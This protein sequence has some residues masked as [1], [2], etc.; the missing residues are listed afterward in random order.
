M[1]PTQII[2]SLKKIEPSIKSLGT[3]LSEL[4]LTAHVGTINKSSLG[5]LPEELKRI[6]RCIRVIFHENEINNA[7][8]Q[9][10]VLE[11][12]Y[13]LKIKITDA[14]DSD[15]KYIQAVEHWMELSY[16]YLEFLSDI[17]P[18]TYSINLITSEE[19]DLISKK[20]AISNDK[21][22]DKKI[23]LLHKLRTL[24]N[25]PQAIKNTRSEFNNY[26]HLERID[27]LRAPSTEFDTRKLLR[28]CEELNICF[29]NNAFFAT[30][31]LLR[32][33][34]DHIPPI[35]KCNSFSE[36]SNNY[37][38]SKSFKKSMKNLQDSSR[39]ISDAILH[40]T[41]RDRETT[42]NENQVDFRADLDVLLAEID[43]VLRNTTTN[44]PNLN[45][46]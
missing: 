20:Y 40:Q 45:H 9:L 19:I 28:L 36:L 4:N 39:N 18:K 41:I 35:F 8:V 33:L 46:P 2:S 17:S 42:P 34:L 10:D 24:K 30:A 12:S 44:Q 11:E 43:R 25:I 31:M 29:S 21:Y 22:I 23:D 38:G 26:I 1:T 5:D 3:N 6:D 14:L 32:S 37:S 15:L 7:W 27:A 16:I 13:R